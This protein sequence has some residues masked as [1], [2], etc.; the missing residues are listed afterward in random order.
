MNLGDMAMNGLERNDSEE[1]EDK[2]GSLYRSRTFSGLL[3]LIDEDSDTEDD[4]A[5]EEVFEE[6]EEKIVEVKE[7]FSLKSERQ[8]HNRDISYPGLLITPNEQLVSPKGKGSGQVRERLFCGNQRKN[9]KEAE[10]CWVQ[11]DRKFNNRNDQSNQNGKYKLTFITSL[12][13][14]RWS[15]RIVMILGNTMI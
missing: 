11:C 1:L 6:V 14:L 2:S 7:E 4:E 15:L 8:M 12:L 3:D 9:Q 13:Y 5:E 10:R